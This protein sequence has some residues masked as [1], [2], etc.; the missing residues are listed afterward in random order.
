M[1]HQLAN[2]VKRLESSVNNLK[3]THQQELKSIQET[4]TEMLIQVPQTNSINEKFQQIDVNIKDL[5]DNLKTCG[6]IQGLEERI[7]II[8][9]CR[10]STDKVS[11]YQSELCPNEL[12][13]EISNE[14]EERRKRQKSVVIH[15]VPE[16]DN[17]IDDV[18]VVTDI[19]QHVKEVRRDEVEAIIVQV[20][21]MGQ[22]HRYPNKG[23]SIK[24]HLISPETRS[25]LIEKSRSLRLSSSTKHK[26]VALQ[27]DL[28]PLE[29]LQLRKLV[30]EKRLHN[31]QAR[32]NGEEPEWIIRNGTLCRKSDLY[33]N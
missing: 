14:I 22:R 13:A 8:E 3:E 15:N 32:G 2:V 16:T 6:S 18:N 27:K 11:P 30:R 7:S 21:L 26:S 19:I 33:L 9:T 17:Q 4:V 29:R 24:V 10:S 20:Y 23:R 12:V 5:N 25:Y 31:T 1:L 28:T